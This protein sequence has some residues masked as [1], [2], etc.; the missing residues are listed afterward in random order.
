M[1]FVPDLLEFAMLRGMQY[2]FR[3]DRNNNHYRL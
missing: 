1:Y 3:A 2:G